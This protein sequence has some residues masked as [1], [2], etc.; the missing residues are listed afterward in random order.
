ML[1]RSTVP[2]PEYLYPDLTRI[3]VDAPW[4]GTFKL[5]QEVWLTFHIVHLFYFD[6]IGL[7]LHSV[8]NF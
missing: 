8:V 3:E 1:F 4:K 5:F 6:G 2:L 7:R